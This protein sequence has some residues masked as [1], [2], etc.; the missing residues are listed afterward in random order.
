MSALAELIEIVR[1]CDVQY[2]DQWYGPKANPDDIAAELHDAI[3]AEAFANAADLVHAMAD[4]HC[5]CGGCDSCAARGYAEELRRKAEEK[6]TAPAAKATPDR[7]DQLLDTI[8]T[9]RGKWTVNRVRDVRR[10]TGGPT[11]RSTARRDLAE[12][13]RRGHLQQHGPQDGRFYTLT[14]HKG[15][16]PE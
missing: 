14:T 2:L 3:R 1:H 5:T 7:V 6:A 9:H 13:H 12:L 16:A 15:V 11:Q 4:P 10:L 8:R